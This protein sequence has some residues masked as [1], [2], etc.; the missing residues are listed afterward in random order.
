VIF[1]RLI[2]PPV[3]AESHLGKFQLA[4]NRHYTH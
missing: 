2:V 4:I 1:H 3:H